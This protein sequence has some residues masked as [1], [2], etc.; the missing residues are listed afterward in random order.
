[1][2]ELTIVSAVAGPAGLTAAVRRALCSDV[3]A[4]RAVLKGLP[5]VTL[6]VETFGM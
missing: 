3:A 2:N 6:H 5:S 4:P 1:M